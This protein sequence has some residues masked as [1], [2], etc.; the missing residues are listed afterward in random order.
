MSNTEN[1]RMQKGSGIYT[2]EECGKKT[3]ETGDGESWVRMCRRCWDLGGLENS[4]S[5]GN[6]TQ[7]EFDRY[8][9]AL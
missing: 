4:L 3:R 1:G 9:A 6:I 5:D 2:C 8:V 7:E